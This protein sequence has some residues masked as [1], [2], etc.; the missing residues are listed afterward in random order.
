ME[1]PEDAFWNR[2]PI[3]AKFGIG[4]RLFGCENMKK[5]KRV[6]RRNNFRKN[7]G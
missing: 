2:L 3:E 7:I 1:Y 5:L 4:V 6:S